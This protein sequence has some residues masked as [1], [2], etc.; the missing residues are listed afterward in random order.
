M[1]A[2]IARTNSQNTPLLPNQAS[3]NRTTIPSDP[4]GAQFPPHKAHHPKSK[5]PCVRLNPL[6][7]QANPLFHQNPFLPI[8]SPLTGAQ[9][10]RTRSVRVYQT[11]ISTIPTARHRRRPERR[12][13]HQKTIDFQSVFSHFFTL[14]DNLA[15][16]V[17][18]STTRRQSVFI[19]MSTTVCLLFSYFVQS[20]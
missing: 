19:Y 18:T 2:T 17:H 5:C 1:P 16:T 4:I 9:V 11:S 12:H 20:S 3:N 13:H 14:S 6:S 10:T 8:P 15:L 7:Q